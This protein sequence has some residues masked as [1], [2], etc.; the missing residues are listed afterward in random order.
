MAC[1]PRPKARTTVPAADLA[2]RPDLIEKEA[3]RMMHQFRKLVGD[4]H[5]HA[6]YPG[7][8]RVPGRPQR[9]LLCSQEGLLATPQQGHM[10]TDLP[11]KR[12]GEVAVRNC[13]SIKGVTILPFRFG[14]H[15]VPVCRLHRHHEQVWHPL[16]RWEEPACATYNVAADIIQR[17]PRRKELVNQQDL[18]HQKKSNQRS[19]H[20]GLNTDCDQ[21]RLQFGDRVPHPERSPSRYGGKPRTTA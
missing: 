13:Q 11:P 16:L 4:H 19:R 9:G 14:K 10:R 8:I 18:P 3:S 6:P 17:H 7:R 20:H 1:Q 15:K 5:P 2:G 21:T 12:P